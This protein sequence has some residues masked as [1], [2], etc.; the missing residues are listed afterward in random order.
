MDTLTLII[1]V[2]AVVLGLVVGILVQ[3]RLAESSKENAESQG[4]KFIE[5]ALVE[6]ERIKQ[7]AVLKSKDDAYQHKQEVDKEIKQRTVELKKEERRF[8]QKLEQIESKIDLLDK[9]E[10]DF[11]KKEKA[12]SK[13]ES[14]LS[15]RK[16]EADALIDEQRT[17]LENI[18]GI[19]REEAQ[20]RLVDSIFITLGYISVV[21]ADEY[22]GYI[23]HDAD[24]CGFCTGLSTY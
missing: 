22:Q 24:H 9:R 23:S 6:S 20:K 15:K 3:K 14:L 5:D 18:A 16:N 8:S 11:H 13:Q 4:K 21:V 1:G 12:F 2:G 7:E 10:T 19:S 17:K